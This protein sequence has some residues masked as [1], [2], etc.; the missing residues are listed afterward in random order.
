[1]ENTSWVENIKLGGEYQAGW[2]IS[3]WV[4]N[5]KLGGEYHTGWRISSWVEINKLWREI[6]GVQKFRQF[7]RFSE[8][9]ESILIICIVSVK[10]LSFWLAT[11]DPP[12]KCLLLYS[13]L[14][15]EFSRDE[16]EI[17]RVVSPFSRLACIKFW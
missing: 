8:I 5:I 13:L 9:Q 15:V 16:S 2:R 7:V 14:V 11:H 6:Y 1:M 12:F 3:S 10:N 4:E 17:V